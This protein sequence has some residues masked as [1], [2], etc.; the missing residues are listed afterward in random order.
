VTEDHNITISMLREHLG[1]DVAESYIELLNAI[2]SNSMGVDLGEI[3]KELGARLEEVKEKTFSLEYR[4]CVEDMYVDVYNMTRAIET[5]LE[6][7]KTLSLCPTRLTRQWATWKQISLAAW[8]L[9]TYIDT[10]I[11]TLQ[12]LEEKNEEVHSS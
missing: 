7:A 2:R 1:D 8:Q 5:L 6:V 3:N 11:V 12:T 4:Q 9:S 10:A